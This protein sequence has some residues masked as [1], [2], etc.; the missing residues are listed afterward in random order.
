MKQKSKTSPKKMRGT[1]VS[2]AT[3][4][5]LTVEVKRLVVHPIYK[6]RYTVS[7]RYKVH[8]EGGEYTPGVVVQFQ[9]T[10]PLSKTKCWVVIDDTKKEV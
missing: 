9:E 10:R 4:K 2:N 7:K 8:Y 3:P 1:V 6:K 5:T